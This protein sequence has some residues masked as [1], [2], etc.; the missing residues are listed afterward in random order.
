MASLAWLQSALQLAY[1]SGALKP[2]RPDAPESPAIDS[3]SP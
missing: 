1:Q 3:K 2:R